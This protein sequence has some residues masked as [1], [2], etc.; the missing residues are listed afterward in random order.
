MYDFVNKVLK[1]NEKDIF[2][3][4][5]SI[6]CS[7]ATFIAKNR[8]PGFCILM[9]PFKSLKQAAVA[10]VGNFLS[11][12]VAERMDNAEMLQDVESPVFIVHG[13]RDELIPFT[14]SQE[15]LDHCYK[16]RHTHLVLPPHMTH[17]K[18]NAETDLVI[19][20]MKFLKQIRLDLS[21][22]TV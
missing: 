14:Q 4:G 12:F 8:S 20:L 16:S 18:F 9:S 17:N 22:T 11:N 19:P 5:R 3:Y 21:V 2:L 7:V 6:G 10:V 1:V 15:L 13:Q